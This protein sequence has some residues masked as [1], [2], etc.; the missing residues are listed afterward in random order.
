MHLEVAAPRGVRGIK[1]MMPESPAAIAESPALLNRLRS[2]SN[3]LVV[4]G[5]I[6]YEFDGPAS[7][8]I[9]NLASAAQATWAIACGP[10]DRDS[11]AK[12]WADRLDGARLPAVYLD[13]NAAPP[14]VPD[15]LL[16][17][18]SDVRQGIL[19]CHQARRLESGLELLD[20]HIQQDLRQHEARRK[21]LMRRNLTLNDTTEER[22]LQDAAGAIRRALDE[23]RE[24]IEAELAERERER[25]LPT[26]VPNN[27][28][29]NLLEDLTTDDI[30]RE[31]L[32]RIVQLSVAPGVRQAVRRLISDLVQADLHADLERLNPSTTAMTQEVVAMLDAAGGGVLAIPPETLDEATVWKLLQ[33]SIHL[34]SRYRSELTQKGTRE[35][36]FEFV[37]HCR[38]PVFLMTIVVSPL[39][40][41]WPGLRDPLLKLSPF[42]FLGGAYWAYRGLKDEEHNA[43]EREVIRLRE[44]LRSEVRRLYEET[45]DDW[46]QRAV[47]HL[48]GVV[49]RIGQKVDERVKARL[50]EMARES[51][52]ERVELQDKLK[53]V[54]IRLRMLGALVQQVGRV[55]QTTAE[56]GLA[57]ERSARDAIR[58]IPQTIKVA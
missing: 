1:L 47:Q 22:A 32:G 3:V 37:M 40:A 19:A 18:G 44:T 15:F 58:N 33:D 14:P 50:V 2:E 17:G 8:T 35:R 42:L 41:F 54:D 6:G 24:K 4:A 43:T 20:D 38:T 11:P 12:G 31:T 16:D 7:E 5:P 51:G 36:L 34:D 49:S 21:A 29:N 25:L 48:N 46:S 30:A 26:S 13:P 23:S 39:C 53:A 9:R 28:I 45:L 55:R 10:A 27:K 52:G 57:L 56:A